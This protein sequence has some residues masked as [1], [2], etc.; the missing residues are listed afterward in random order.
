MPNAHYQTKEYKMLKACAYICLSSDIETSNYGSN[1]IEFY[2]TRTHCHGRH[3]WNTLTKPPTKNSNVFFSNRAQT[4]KQ[5]SVS[6]FVYKQICAPRFYLAFGAVYVDLFV[7][8]VCMH[9]HDYRAISL[10]KRKFGIIISITCRPNK[11]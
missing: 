6:K 11:Q 3:K 2:A 7:T 1:K 5:S 4:Q 10:R 9:T 8:S